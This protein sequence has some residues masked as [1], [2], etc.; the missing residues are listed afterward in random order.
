M[1]FDLQ[2][3]AHKFGQELQTVLDGVLPHQ[4]GADPE[5]RQVAV[6]AAG[7]AFTV[8]IGTAN[9][10]K[11]VPIPLLTRG[12]KTA[13]LR[14][15]IRLV[16][17]SVQ[18][19]PA[20][21]QSEYSLR[22]ERHPLVRLDFGRDF[23]SAPSCHWNVHAERGAVTRLLG[24]NLPDHS[25]ELSKVHLPV[26]GPRMRP[27]IED[28]LQMLILEFGFDAV[29]GWQQVLDDG[30]V[31]WRRRQLAAMIRDDAEHAAEVL[32]DRLGYE[33]APPAG[34]PTPPKMD[35]ITTW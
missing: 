2:D 28:F 1:T 24:H 12:E 4:E 14:V 3:E 13:D 8:E 33:V 15:H 10:G 11:A 25:G 9:C 20:V 16:A 17:D 35:K 23:H 6:I 32:R 31:R 27:C 26:G 22:I 34:G 19:F 7:L 29:D 18:K 21:A 5:L 30:R